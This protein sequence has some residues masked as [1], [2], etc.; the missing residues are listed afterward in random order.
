[1]FNFD[2]NGFTYPVIRLNESQIGKL[3]K[4][5]DYT[6]RTNDDISFCITILL[7]ELETSE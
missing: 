3:G 7:N 1:M 6:I 4:L 2:E 5:V